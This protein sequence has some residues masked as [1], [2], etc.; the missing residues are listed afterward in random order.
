[1]SIG[2]WIKGASAVGKQMFATRGQGFKADT[3]VQPVEASQIGKNPFNP[4]DGD[5]RYNYY[6]DASNGVEMLSASGSTK[7]H[8]TGYIPV[9]PGVTYRRSDAF[10]PVGYFDRGRTWISGETPGATFTAPDDAYFVRLSVRRTAWSSFA[11][12]V[13]TGGQVRW[14][15]FGNRQIGPSQ[16]P[17][18]IGYLRRIKYKL[19]KLQLG[20]TLRVGLNISGD[21]YSQLAVRWTAPFMTYMA[22]KYGDGGGG[23]CGFGFTSAGT[24]PYTVANQP[25]NKNGNVRPTTYPTM[26]FGAITTSYNGEN[27][28]DLSAVT[29]AASG[30]YVFQAFPALP[31]HNGCDLFFVGTSNGVVRYRYGTY[32]G[33][34]DVK[35]PENYT[36]GSNTN[37]NVQGTVGAVQTADIST[38]IPSGAGAVIIEWVSG[39]SKLAGLNLK[40]AASGVYVNKIAGSGSQ[41]A[42]W[43]GKDAT[44][45]QNG[46]AA[47]GGD[48]FIYM[49]GP[50]SQ[51]SNV[52]PASWGTNVDTLMSRV[53]VAIPGADILLATP[54]ENPRSTNRVAILGYAVEA[55]KRSIQ[56]RYAYLNCQ[57]A[58][59]DAGNPSE[60]ASDGIVPLFN[61]DELHP[62]D[63]TGGRLLFKEFARAIDPFTS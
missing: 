1:M 34:G 35:D 59:G 54:P 47:L 32:D 61:S 51:S 37:I 2:D 22:G 10:G 27:T 24:T 50:N 40:S 5:V 15:V 20:E 38:G 7:Y 31:I 18:N 60:Y 52:E 56:G 53:R 26:I 25:T 41:V 23:W 57:P 14:D 11:I 4:N 9:T 6:I 16:N 21:S 42:S 39:T 17:M 48:A 58:F 3:A 62:E 45:W 33:S 44:N 46:L 29:L 8:L 43:A 55:V 19:A 63:S 13:D 36:F 49:D 12:A 28:P 30:D